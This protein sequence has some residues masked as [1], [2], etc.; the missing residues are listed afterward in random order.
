M[1]VTKICTYLYVYIHSTHMH[2]YAYVYINVYMYLCIYV[3]I[4]VCIQMYP[5]WYIGVYIHSSCVCQGF[6]LAL[7]IQLH[8]LPPTTSARK[9]SHY[10]SPTGGN[11]QTKESVLDPGLTR[12]HS[13]KSKDTYVFYVRVVEAALYGFPSID[14]KSTNVRVEPGSDSIFELVVR[15]AVCWRMSSRHIAHQG[16]PQP[17]FGQWEL[18]CMFRCHLCRCVK[19]KEMDGKCFVKLMKDS[20][21]IGSRFTTTDLSAADWWEMWNGASRG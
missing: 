15:G 5:Y 18:V 1:I 6:G 9:S 8:G 20:K 16:R 3:Y 21:M 14:P 7:R 11:T 12:C 13:R 2:T 10:H 4:H 17:G 19:D